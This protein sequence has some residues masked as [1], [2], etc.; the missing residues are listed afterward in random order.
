M[1]KSLDVKALQSRERTLFSVETLAVI[2]VLAL[3]ALA[4]NF[5]ILRHG[6][7]FDSHD[8]LIHLRCCSTF[9]SSSL[10]EVCIRAG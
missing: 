1:Q 5:K 10:K 9:L 3:A 7:I 8:L 6:I 4:I 2:A